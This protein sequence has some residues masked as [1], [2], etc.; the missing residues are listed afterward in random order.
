M[1][2]PWC[3]CLRG[4]RVADVGGG[5]GRAHS[6][7]T[8]YCSP[9]VRC[10][11]GVTPG[12]VGSTLSDEQLVGSGTQTQGRWRCVETERLSNLLKATPLTPTILFQRSCSHPLFDSAVGFG[13]R[14]GLSL[15]VE[16]NL[17]SRLRLAAH[18]SNHDL[19][20]RNFPL[21]LPLPEVVSW[22]TAGFSV[23]G[24]CPHP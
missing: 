4:R 9:N 21:G 12:P 16:G 22:L 1:L 14:G 17:G 6:P 18:S 19:C 13:R 8:R 10:V 20:R 23:R 2:H 11:L 3:L 5:W 15:P 7:S 24:Y